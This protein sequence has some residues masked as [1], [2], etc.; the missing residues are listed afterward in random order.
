MSPMTARRVVLASACDAR[1][2]ATRTAL[3]TGSLDQQSASS[4]AIWPREAA[5]WRELTRFGCP[6]G[7][8]G[9][10]WFGWETR[11]GEWGR[12]WLRG[13][14]DQ[15]SSLYAASRAE[16]PSPRSRAGL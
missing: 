8:A 7:V 15:A 12:T 14:R 9:D 3:S 5:R 13:V 6:D 2:S 10:P 4:S 16:R 1:T 11:K